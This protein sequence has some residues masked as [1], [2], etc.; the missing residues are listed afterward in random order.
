MEELEEEKENANVLLAYLWVITKSI[1]RTVP[2][3]NVGDAD[4]ALDT[5][6]NN[7]RARLGGNDTGTGNGGGGPAINVTLDTGALA[8]TQAAL[9]NSVNALNTSLLANDNEKKEKKSILHGMAPNSRRLFTRLCTTDI[10]GVEPVMTDFLKSLIAERNPSHVTNHL[11]GVTKDWKGTFIDGAFC[12]F[13]AKGYVSQRDTL[14]PGG[15]TIFM[16]LPK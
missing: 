4:E 2:V 6:C 11:R 10:I 5:K 16:F 1:C 15:F 3:I 9:L 8:A 7:M 14:I 12:R 13:L